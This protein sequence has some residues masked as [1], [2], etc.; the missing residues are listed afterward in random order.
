MPPHDPLDCLKC[1]ALCCRMAGYVRVS[2]DDI[3]RLAKFL[4]LTVR[5]FEERHIIEKT[6][7]GEKRI[8]AGYRTCQFLTPDRMCGVY[9]ARPRDCRGY[10]CWNQDDETVYD[11]ARF[12]QMPVDNLRAGEVAADAKE[13]LARAKRQA[14]R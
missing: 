2:R 7:K 6:R 11:F 8:K 10:V 12:L 3:R 13:K 14:R 1:P 5:Q 4:N 9:E